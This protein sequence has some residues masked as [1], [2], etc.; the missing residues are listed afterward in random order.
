MHKFLRNCKTPHAIFSNEGLSLLRYSD[1]L[2]RLAEMMNGDRLRIILYLRNK[3]DFLRSYTNQ[4]CKVRG[5]YPLTD[6]TSALYV[7]PDSWLVDYKTLIEVYSTRFGRENILV[8]N[9]D[10]ELS[11]EGNTLTSFQDALELPPEAKRNPSDYW[12]NRS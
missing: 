3:E 4:I 6:P 12:L 10:Q 1:E 11:K 5:R 9:Y 8:K 2:D 7:A